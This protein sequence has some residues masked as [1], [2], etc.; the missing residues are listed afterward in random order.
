V[1]NSSLE[2]DNQNPAG[3]SVERPSTGA[4]AQQSVNVIGDTEC[5]PQKLVRLVG[6][7]DPS[8]RIAHPIRAIDLARR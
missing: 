8:A 5:V 1:G 3:T 2:V 6:C 4:M 7:R